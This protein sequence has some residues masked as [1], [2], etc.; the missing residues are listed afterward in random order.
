MN[1][2]AH[3]MA[4]P[5]PSGT[6]WRTVTIEPGSHLRG[7][8][9]LQLGGLAALAQRRLQLEGD[10][11][12]FHQRGLAAAGDH[13]ELLDPGRPRFLDRVLDQRLVHHRQHL[14]GGGLGGRQ[15]SSAE[16]SNRQ[17]GFAQW[18]N[19]DELPW[20]PMGRRQRAWRAG[21]NVALTTEPGSDT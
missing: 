12:M 2:R 6:C 15:E 13:A 3:Q 5:R 8:Q 21:G 11:E 1:A 7:A 9:H 19:H 14:L 20:S 16:A 10:V 17:H 4:W 18:S